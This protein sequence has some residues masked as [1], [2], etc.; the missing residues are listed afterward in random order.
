MTRRSPSSAIVEP[1]TSTERRPDGRVPVDLDVLEPLAAGGAHGGH[2]VG[3]ERAPGGVVEPVGLRV[4]LGRD[5]QRSAPPA[6]RWAA[7]LAKSIRAVARLDEDQ[8]H[9][10]D[11]EDRLDI[12]ARMT[13]APNSPVYGAYAS[14]RLR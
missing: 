4:V 9:G 8:R 12:Q 1:E 11:V 6:S 10:K 5:A 3:P 13:Q 2:L 14:P 7:A